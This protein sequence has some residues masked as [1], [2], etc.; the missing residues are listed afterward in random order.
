MGV[1]G[2]CVRAEAGNHSD[3]GRRHIGPALYPN[4]DRTD[5][6]LAGIVDGSADRVENTIH[7]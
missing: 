2:I 7:C 1:K 3:R 4:L 5:T 6:S